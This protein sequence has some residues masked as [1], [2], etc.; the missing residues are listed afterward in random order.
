MPRR[1]RPENKGLPARWR[2]YHGAYYYL[3]PSG[4]EHQWDGKK[5]FRLG[6]NLIEAYRCWSARL[7]LHAEA[8]SIG[9]LLERYVLEVVPEKAPKSQT[10]N[11]AA[12]RR[13]KPVFGHMPI[14]GL[15]PV[16][17]Y[18]YLDKRGKTGRTAANREIEVLSHAYTKAIEWGLTDTHPIKQKVRKLSTPPRTRYIEDWEIVE[19]LSIAR[20]GSAAASRWSVRT[21]SSNF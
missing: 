1:R 17:V 19:A 11:I 14:T 8:K 2:Y 21:S 3:V 6:S 10:N 13:L 4:M 7:E 20:A 18:G 16:H 9:E 5:Q 15:K 12:L